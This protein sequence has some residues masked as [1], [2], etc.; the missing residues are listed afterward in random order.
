MTRAWLATTAGAVVAHGLTLVLVDGQFALALVSDPFGRDWDLFGTADRAIDYSPLSPGAIGIAQIALAIAGATA[1]VV[2]AARTLAA[3][4]SAGLDARG[5]LGAL[6]ATGVAS[7]CTVAAVIA[8][9]SSDL[10]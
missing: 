5:A 8:L 2:A 6:W 9:L 1:G 7:A 3:G 10:E 4:R